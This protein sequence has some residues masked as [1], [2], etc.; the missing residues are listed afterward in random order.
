M[1]KK[2]LSPRVLLIFLLG[3]FLINI[4]IGITQVG[5]IT[6]YPTGEDKDNDGVGDDF[7]ELNFRN[8]E[9]E[10]DNSSFEIDSVLRE[11]SQKDEIDINVNYEDELTI[12]VS[13]YNEDDDEDSEI[14]FGVIFQQIIEFNDTDNDGI[15]NSS[16][17]ATVQNMSL[18]PIS[19]VDNFTYSLSEETDLYY[20][21]FTTDNNNFSI[22]MY[23]AEEFTIY[24]NTLINPT[25]AKLDI[26]ISNFNYSVANSSLALKTKLVSE[27]EYEE[28]DDIE[29]DD[30]DDDDEEEEGIEVFSNGFTGIFSW[31][32][33]ATI[34]GESQ[35]VNT[36]NIE[37]EN[38]D[39]IFYLIYPHGT[40]IYHDPTIGMLNVL[41][42]AN[43]GQP[44]NFIISV[45]IIIG[46]VSI[47]V[48][49]ISTYWYYKNRDIP[50]GG[51]EKSIKKGKISKIKNDRSDTLLN[52][53]EGEN[54]MQT[55]E[56]MDNVELTAFRPAYINQVEQLD[57]DEGEKLLFLREMASLNPKERDEILKKMKEKI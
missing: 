28:D 32:K 14:E 44:L 53:A 12:E 43:G 41:K 29:E 30:D 34:D 21:K 35:L 39:K 27:Y 16:T 2:R 48:G 3:I 56:K 37:I 7:E 42:Y 31:H 13:Y 8:I 46:A 22:H 4:T 24:N 25:Q 6:G 10:Y 5:F 23:V 33:N 38:E 49:A 11:G 20:F 36:T 51:G 54:F 18:K 19:L 9:V 1:R 55:I 26:E 47:S 50:L 40:E 15:Y 52:L 57:W 17:D 45:A